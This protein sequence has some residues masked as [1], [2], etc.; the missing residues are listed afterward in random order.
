MHADA[1][2]AGLELR[3]RPLLQGQHP[4]AQRCRGVTQ[5]CAH[6][7]PHA[8]GGLLVLK[9]VLP[10]LSKVKMRSLKQLRTLAGLSL[11]KVMLCRKVFPTLQVLQASVGLP[12]VQ[13]ISDAGATWCHVAVHW[14]P[15]RPACIGS[16]LCAW[17]GDGRR[18]PR[19]VRW[20]LDATTGIG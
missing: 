8:N 20:R 5:G 10:V 13:D 18:A 4:A 14:R 12:S 3:A 9:L 6:K 15:H 11:R 2:V 19:S 1:D 17:D 7:S 16:S